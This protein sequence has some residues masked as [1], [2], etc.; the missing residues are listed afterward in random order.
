MARAGFTLIELIVVLVIVTLL[1]MIAV[2]QMGNVL[3]QMKLKSG[4]REVMGALRESRSRAI[5]SNSDVVFSLDVDRHRYLI[6]GDKKTHS[7]SGNSKISL[8]TVQR[9]RRSDAL[10]GIR[11]FPDGSSTGGR[12]VLSDAKSSYEISVDWFT[13]RVVI[14]QLDTVARSAEPQPER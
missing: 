7:I 11:F 2:P 1:F 8:Y 4:A 3:P 6:S 12:V 10:G 13:G 9:K 5:M 14:K